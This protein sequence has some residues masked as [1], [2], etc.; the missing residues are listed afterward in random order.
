M[1]R[2]IRSELVRVRRSWPMLVVAMV[3]AAVATATTFSATGGGSG[4]R[5]G[6]STSET[7]TATA[8]AAQAL[9]GSGGI[10]AGL[11]TVAPILGLLTLVLW[12]SS[13]ARDF[14][15]GAI[16]VLL[17]TQSRRGVYFAGK[18]IALLALT[19]TLAMAAT[20]VAVGTAL[21]LAPGKDISTTSWTIA[22]V[23]SGLFNTLVGML[24]WGAIGTVL[25]AATR[26]VATAIAGGLGYLVLGEK[27]IALAWSSASDWLPG[28]VIT[29]V[30]NGGGTTPYVQ[31]LLMVL[32]VVVLAVAAS[33]AVVV[34][35]DV[36]D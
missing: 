34:R 14:Q 3:L 26:S 6:S 2:A 15:T 33:L 7:A 1:I 28:G 11:A 4:S 24:A 29:N 35:R 21:L 23:G 8:T 18:L 19:A 32:G 17:V 31:S 22:A 10:V 20:S 5:G 12:G 25:A 13:V 16:R 30:F 9:T 27:L 36:T